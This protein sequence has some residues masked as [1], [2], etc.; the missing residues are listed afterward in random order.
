MKKTISLPP[1][2]NEMLERE[3]KRTGLPMS[4]V[5]RKGLDY[6]FSAAE[7]W[8]KKEEGHGHPEGDLRTDK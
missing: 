8:Q 5:I 2:Y 7:V 1:E 6:Y 4:V 3:K